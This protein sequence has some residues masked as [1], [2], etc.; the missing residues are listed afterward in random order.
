MHPTG[1]IVLLSCV[2]ARRYK[3]FIMLNSSIKG[4]F[5]PQYMPKRWHWVDAFLELYEGDVHAV[6]SSLVCL[7][8][9]D[10]GACCRTHSAP[11]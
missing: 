4:P 3:Y 2:A 8:V 10:A 5:F 6:A 9:I 11:E 7:P 1:T